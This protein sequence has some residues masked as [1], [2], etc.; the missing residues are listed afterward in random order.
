MKRLVA[1]TVITASSALWAAPAEAS[2]TSSSTSGLCRIV[3]L[4]YC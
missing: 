3:T 1:L 4:W 2:T